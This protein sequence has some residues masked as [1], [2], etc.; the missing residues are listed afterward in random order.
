MKYP[1]E[2]EGYDSMQDLAEDLGN[3]RYDILAEFLSELSKKI[4]SDSA[5][6]HNNGRPLLAGELYCAGSALESVK[7]SVDKAWYYCHRNMNDEDCQ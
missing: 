5:N 3:L 1:K 6:D 2:I 7:E 4:Y